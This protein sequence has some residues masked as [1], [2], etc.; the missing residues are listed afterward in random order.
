MS[1]ARGAARALGV[2]WLGVGVILLLVPSHYVPAGVIDDDGIAHALAFAVAVALWTVAL[3]N[4]AA[5][6]LAAAAVA[7]AG[8]EVA[9]GAITPTR[10]AEWA[11]VAAN[12]GGVAV[13]LAVGL[14]L[15]KGVEGWERWAPGRR[16][17]GVPRG[18]R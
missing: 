5:W 17:R 7:A 15:S 1:R 3:P 13:G 8:S 2:V 18:P 6:V 9:Q 4:R 14:A 11:D 12:L 16:R 10:G